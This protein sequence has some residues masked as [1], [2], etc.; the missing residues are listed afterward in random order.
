MCPDSAAIRP[1]QPNQSP[2]DSS[3]AAFNAIASPPARDSPGRATRL[4]TMTSRLIAQDPCSHR[5]APRPRQP[6]RRDD[7]PDVRV[8]LREVAPWLAVE[9]E[10][11]GQQAQRIAAR[12]QALEHPAR[13]LQAPYRS[14]RVDVPEGADGEAGFRNAEVIRCDVAE[15]CIAMQQLAT[16]G[17]DGGDE[18]RIVRGDE[19]QVGQQQQRSV[20]PV[21]AEGV[22]EM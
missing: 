6:H 14:E 11:L 7:E 19:T 8:R 17:F 4:D 20:E 9:G 16:D 18:A 2:P 10:V 15:Q 22:D 1:L 12:E 13:F 3:I 21:S 5:V